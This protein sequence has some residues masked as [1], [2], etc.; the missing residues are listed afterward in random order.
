MTSN[1]LLTKDDIEELKDSNKADI[2]S[3]ISWARSD[4]NA[5]LTI[6]EI[7]FQV[8]E[9]MGADTPYLI[10]EL[11]ALTNDADIS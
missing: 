2:A 4:P 7:A 5:A 9:G 6:E 3:R 1:P 10:K 11:Q 8:K